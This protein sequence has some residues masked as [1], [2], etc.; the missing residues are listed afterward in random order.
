MV[1]EKRWGEA[2]WLSLWNCVIAELQAN[3]TPGF[4]ADVLLLRCLGSKRSFPGA[5]AALPGVLEVVSKGREA[6]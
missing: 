2:A 5:C 3:L 4:L 6:Q 1:G